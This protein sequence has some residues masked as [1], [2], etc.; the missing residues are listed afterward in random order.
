MSLPAAAF[1][2]LGSAPISRLA[3]LSADFSPGV[4]EAHGL[5]FIEGRGGGDGGNGL[6]YGGGNGGFIQ[7]VRDGGAR[8]SF[9]HLLFLA[10][11][12][13][14]PTARRTRSGRG[15]GCRQ[16]LWSRSPAEIAPAGT[17]RPV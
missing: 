12:R 3:R 10:T 9:S 5:E 4:R 13:I 1:W 6:V 8:Q 17:R 11:S 2:S 16:G 7:R 15:T 14:M